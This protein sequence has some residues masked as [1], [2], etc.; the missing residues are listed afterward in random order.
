MEDKNNYYCIT[1][2]RPNNYLAKVFSKS[3]WNAMKGV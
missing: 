1:F 3:N 2:Y